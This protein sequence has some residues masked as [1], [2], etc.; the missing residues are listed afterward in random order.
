M[1]KALFFNYTQVVIAVFAILAA[2]VIIYLAVIEVRKNKISGKP[3]ISSG[4]QELGL[5]QLEN[6]YLHVLNQ[7][8]ISFWF[9][10]LFAS[11][12]FIII[13]ISGFLYAENTLA[14]TIISMISGTVIDAVSA[15]FFIQSRRAQQNMNTF[16]QKLREDNQ[17]IE[18]KN[19][20]ESV[21]SAKARDALRIQLALS[22]SN[23]PESK[24]IGDEIIKSCITEEKI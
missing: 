11:I 10:L 6:Y 9:S 16:F 15:L 13:I 22:L 5:S 20:C 12:G 18:A 3:D 19:L 4:Q 7:S 2:L 8:K 23:I 1:T 14:S 24:E 17:L 21:E